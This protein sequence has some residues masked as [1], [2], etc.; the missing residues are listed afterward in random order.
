MSL[1]EIRE[2]PLELTGDQVVSVQGG[3]DHGGQARPSRTGDWASLLD[4]T[5]NLIIE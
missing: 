4:L 2:S 5:S 1:G 3:A